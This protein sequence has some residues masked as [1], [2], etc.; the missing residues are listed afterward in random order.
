M[1]KPFASSDTEYDKTN[2][3]DS[4]SVTSKSTVNESSSLKETELISEIVGI[5]LT[6]NI[7]KIIVASSDHLSSSS[8]SGS[9]VLNALYILYRKLSWSTSWSYGK[10]WFGV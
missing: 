6:W 10:S 3:S 1:T 4:G 8:V 9:S 2:E 7:L 5:S